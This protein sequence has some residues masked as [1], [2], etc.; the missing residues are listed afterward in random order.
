MAAGP[1]PAPQDGT[2]GR[3]QRFEGGRLVLEQLADVDAGWRAGPPQRG[4]AADLRE[5]E[6]ELPALGDEREDVDDLGRID[7][8]AGCRAPHRREDAPRLVEPERLAAHPT[9][10]GHLADQQAV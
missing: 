9:A 2:H 3:Q 4:D 6:A 5:R 8:I 1:S 7:P 10:T